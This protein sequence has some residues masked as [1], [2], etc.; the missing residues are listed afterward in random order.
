MMIKQS[1]SVFA[2]LAG[3]AALVFGSPALENVS[4]PVDRAQSTLY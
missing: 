2:E 3:K 4:P 1:L